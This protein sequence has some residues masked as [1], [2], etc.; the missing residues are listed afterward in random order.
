[1][2]EFGINLAK[3]IA[4][5]LN[6]DVDRVVELLNSFNS[7][8]PE[9]NSIPLKTNPTDDKTIK[10]SKSKTQSSIVEKKTIPST[11]N[12]AAISSGSSK[13]SKDNHPCE[14][15]KQNQSDPCGK[16]ATR[17]IM[18]NNKKSWFC[19]GEKSGCYPFMIKKQSTQSD[20]LPKSVNITEKI[21]KNEVKK[22]KNEKPGKVEEPKDLLNTMIKNRNIQMSSITTKTHGKLFM[23][24]TRRL[25]AKHNTTIFYGVLAEDND[26]INPITDNEMIKWIESN[27]WTVEQ[28]TKN[29]VQPKLK[30]RDKQCEGAS[31]IKGELSNEHV[32]ATSSEEE[33]ITIAEDEEGESSDEG[34]AYTS[35]NTTGESSNEEDEDNISVEK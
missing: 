21:S 13:A 6:V 26:T 10:N 4:T 5:G 23:D 15:I 9:T 24:H 29:N 2:S 14:R 25:L 11:K 19:G 1:M 17:Y 32:E 27:G 30:G 8:R 34:G 7:I 28:L 3:H 22:D 18:I 16:N 12:A 33:Q 35:D 20:V 31:Q